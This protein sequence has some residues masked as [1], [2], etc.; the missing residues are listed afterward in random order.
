MSRSQ[1]WSFIIWAIAVGLPMTPWGKTTMG[2]IFLSVAAIAFVWLTYTWLRTVRIIDEVEPS[3]FASTPIEWTLKLLILLFPVILLGTIAIL[4]R[5]PTDETL[6]RV[7]S[8]SLDQASVGINCTPESL[9]LRGNHGDSL[10]AIYLH[11]KWGN[12]LVKFL[13]GSEEASTY[14]PNM[15]TIG[16]AYQCEIVNHGNDTI[17]GLTVLFRVKFTGDNRAQRNRTIEIGFPDPIEAHKRFVFHAVDD[18]GWAPKVLMPEGVSARINGEPKNRFI[19]VQYSTV[20]GTPS[21]LA[22]FGP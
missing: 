1:I 21:E 7:S 18:T 16:V 15:K 11:P 3:Q 14:W 2:Y 9:P 13:F 17:L 8:P 19:Q 10:Y 5:E 12:E 22:G 20:N 6:T 4:L